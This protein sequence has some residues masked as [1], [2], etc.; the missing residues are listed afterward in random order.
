[1]EELITTDDVMLPWKII[2]MIGSVIITAHFV[3][4]YYWFI[5][6]CESYEN[7]HSKNSGPSK[8]TG[9]ISMKLT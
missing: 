4:C 2:K 5:A 8:H 1:M 3:A 6:K 7:E 9:I